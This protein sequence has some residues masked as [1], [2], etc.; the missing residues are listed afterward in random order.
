MKVRLRFAQAHSGAEVWASNLICALK[1][2]GIKITFETYKLYN[3]VLPFN[4]NKLDDRYDVL[5]TDILGFKF[6]TKKPMVVVEHHMITDPI[7]RGYTSVLQK[8]FNKSLHYYE[9][10]TLQKADRI[11]CVS[12]YTKKRLRELLGFNSEVIHNGVDTQKFRPRKLKRKNNKIRLLFVGNL[13]KRKGADLLPKIM[14]ILGE[15]YELY[16]TAGLRSKKSL[17]RKNMIPLGRISNKELIKEYNKCDILLFPTRLEGFGYAAAEAMACE[18]P[19]VT[20]N[21]S[22][23]PELVIDKKGG[24]LCEMD[25]VN[26]F[27]EKIK[28][29]AKDEKLRESMGQF[30]R[31]AVLKNFSLEKMGEKYERLYRKLL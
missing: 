20:T 14:K 21:C 12:E 29:L 22:S 17:K 15:D 13:I 31:K 2:R 8:I 9:L 5:Q 25:N 7:L 24:F 30:N 27:I 19:I 18:K 28:I 11:I 16:Y 10:K 6:K 3:Y 26:D 23:L 4:T 1:K